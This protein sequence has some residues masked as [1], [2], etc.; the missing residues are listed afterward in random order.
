M[1][2]L[3][4]AGRWAVDHSLPTVLAAN[5]LALAV[6]FVGPWLLGAP[7]T[8]EFLL[9]NLA[10]A[11]APFI[12]ALGVEAYARM[13]RRRSM[14][15]C[16]VVWLLFLPNAPYVITDL[17]HLGD[18]PATPW[19]NFAR[20]V[21][22]GWAGLLLGLASLRV[23]QRTVE[24]RSGRLA[25]WALVV[26]AAVASGIGIAIGRFGRLNSWQVVTQPRLVASEVLRLSGSPQAIGVAGFFCF[27][28]LVMYTG[29]AMY[30]MPRQ[31]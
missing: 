24:S 26:M 17:S 16:G 10:L 7:P 11:W 12:A 21:A 28:V 8:H 14:W 6:F 22:F 1:T 4:G 19:L 3:R 20:F 31:G 29:M 23:V 13:G 15:A 27:L 30:R 5:A 25:G 18:A 2:A 9:P